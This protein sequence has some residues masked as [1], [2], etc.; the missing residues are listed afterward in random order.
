M[1]MEPKSNVERFTGN[2]DAENRALECSAMGVLMKRVA[3]WSVALIW[4]C[5]LVLR[6]RWQV[7]RGRR[8]DYIQLS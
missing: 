5:F 6:R 4:A 1:A 8:F 7:R 3:L 2:S